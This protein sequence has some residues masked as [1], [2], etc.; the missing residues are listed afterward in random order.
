MRFASAIAG[1]LLMIAAVA[2]PGPAAGDALVTQ[3]GARFE[4]KVA[5][6]AAADTYTLETSTGSRITFPSSMVKEVISGTAAATATTPTATPLSATSATATLP[7]ATS[8][9][10][11]S[12]TST[13]ATSPKKAKEPKSPKTAKTSTSAPSGTVPVVM[14]VPGGPIPI[15]IVNNTGAPFSLAVSSDPR[16]INRRAYAVATGGS[17]SLSLA[18]GTYM[19]FPLMVQGRDVSSLGGGSV[20]VEKPAQ[21]VYTFEGTP[22][23]GTVVFNIVDLPTAPAPTSASGKSP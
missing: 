15:R 19:L 17:V 1:I 18:P 13:S 23:K 2:V 5:F 4:G 6:D 20:K 10:A 9:A 12:P 7:A 22:D 16:G 21:W 11:A 3:S 8:S 14:Y